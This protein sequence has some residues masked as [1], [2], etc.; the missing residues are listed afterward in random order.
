[1]S[2]PFIF[3]DGGRANANF[4][5]TTRD[6]VTRAVAIAAAVDYREAYETV[7]R[8]AEVER[9]RKGGNRSA[10]R[11]GVHKRTTRLVM[12]H[13]GGLWTPAMSI[14]SGCTTHLRADELPWGRI[15]VN[16]SRHVAAV[17]D[18]TL[19]DLDDC[20]RDGTRCVYGYWRFP[21]FD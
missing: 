11:T 1:M 16:L 17:I 13:F 20:S 4:R 15:V 8:Y 5:G 2:I 10:A 3:S 7:N 9:P 6:C 18:G 14:G 21:S 19:Y 12:E